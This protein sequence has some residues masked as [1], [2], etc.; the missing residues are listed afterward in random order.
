MSLG[1][2]SAR[3]CAL[4]LH[5]D[6]NAPTQVFL[7]RDWLKV[8]R[9]YTGPVAAKVVD[10]QPPTYWP[11]VSHIREAMNRLA[12]RATISVW[13]YG[14]LPY[15]AP[16]VVDTDVFGDARADLIPGERHYVL[17]TLLRKMDAGRPP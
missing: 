6:T 11:H 8:R 4:L 17:A 3:G 14:L 13:S 9:I 7:P 2:F 16:R 15:P 10:I 5:L 12:V 1:A